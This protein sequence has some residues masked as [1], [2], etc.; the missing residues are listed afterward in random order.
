VLCLVSA[1]QRR[2]LITKVKARAVDT[3]FPPEADR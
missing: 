1:C 2:L 3:P